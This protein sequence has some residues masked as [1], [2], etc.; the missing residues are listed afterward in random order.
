MAM[1]SQIRSETGC[2]H[3]NE[4]PKIALQ[5]MPPIQR[6]YWTRKGWSRP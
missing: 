6:Q 1:R 3:S 5:R 4:M 2:C